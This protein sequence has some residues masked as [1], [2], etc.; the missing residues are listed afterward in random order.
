M[1]YP[2]ERQIAMS[3]KVDPVEKKRNTP[4]KKVKPTAMKRQNAMSVKVVEPVK[5][6]RPASKEVEP[7]INVDGVVAASK[8]VQ[9]L[10]MIPPPHCTSKTLTVEETIDRVVVA[11]YPFPDAIL[12]GWEALVDPST[13]ESVLA[14]AKASGKYPAWARLMT[15]AEQRRRILF[16][17]MGADVKADVLRKLAANKAWEKQFGCIRF[18]P[19]TD[20]ELKLHQFAKRSD[21][22]K[23]NEKTVSVWKGQFTTLINRQAADKHRQLRAMVQSGRYICFG[24]I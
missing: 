22:P 1:P 13:K 12:G 7:V 2:L 4:S 16:E 3:E 20:D 17:A 10:M 19:T 15:I 24:L 9:T 21:N 5:Q 6:K 11:A 23:E 14:Q 8:E 18:Q